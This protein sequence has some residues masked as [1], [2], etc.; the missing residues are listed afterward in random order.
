MK[1]AVAMLVIVL[2]AAGRVDAQA[3]VSFIP[4]VSL[5]TV[6]DDNL[7]ARARGSAGQMLEL[8]PRF[9][10][11][12]ESARTQL[13]GLDAFDMQKSNHSALN[14]L[15][16]RRHALGTVRY[17]ITPVTTVGL[18]LRYDRTETPG[19]LNL[20]TGVLG[21][22][23]TADRWEATPA[24]VHRFSVQT[25]ATASYNGMTE[26]LVAGDRGTLHVARAG[27][28]RE[29]GSR[30]AITG[31]YVGR[32]FVDN[33]ERHVS[34]AALIGW[35][36]ETSPGTRVTLSAGPKVTSYGGVV[37]EVNAGYARH[38]NRVDLAVDYVHGETIVLGIDG[39][40][41]VDSATSRLTWP[42]TRSV[43]IGLHAGASD[44]VTLDDRE[45]NIY[46]GA[47]V[48]SWSPRASTYTVAATYGIDAQLG[49]IRRLIPGEDAVPPGQYIFRHVLRV[50]L[51]VAPR[52]SRSLLPPEEVARAKGVTR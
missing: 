27:L 51:T 21:E 52:L 13:L 43:E 10:G 37:P 28:S 44:I 23:R 26:S 2:V 11:N 22:R 36:R 40:V 25:S 34:H 14:T 18:G 39:P 19:E 31:S 16:A 48:A 35:S 49:T 6:Y 20:E 29:L 24:L 47:L 30:T 50:G 32:Y 41:A 3:R 38:T 5:F 17:R 42:V 1:P 46:R 7:F 45:M 15:D 4:S 33:V 9:E 12:Y 8:R